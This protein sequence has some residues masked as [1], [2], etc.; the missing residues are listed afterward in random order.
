MA[1][2]AAA[3]WRISGTAEWRI[4]GPASVRTFSLP[5]DTDAAP[6]KLF[7][8]GDA[9]FSY[10][11]MCEAPCDDA[12]RCTLV[13]DFVAGVAAA[14]RRNGASLD[15]F[16]ELLYVEAQRRRQ[17]RASNRTLA[18]FHVALQRDPGPPSAK[19]KGASPLIPFRSRAPAA[20]Q[21]KIYGILKLMYDR[22]GADMYDDELK[23]RR[24][25]RS[26]SMVADADHAVAKVSKASDASD[27]SEASKTAKASKVSKVSN[28]SEPSVP[29]EGA[30]SL[31]RMHYADARSETVVRRLGLSHPL[32]DADAFRA[33][34]RTKTASGPS[35]SSAA[36]GQVLH[37]LL[38]ER[39]CASALASALGPAAAA[40]AMGTKGA[41][42]GGPAAAGT[43]GTRRT[44]PHR[45]AKQFLALRE[46]AL[47]E[48]LRRY[49]RDEIAKAVRALR[50]DADADAATG[51]LDVRK[52][53]EVMA[54][55]VRPVIMD[56][57]LLCRFARLC[58]QRRAAPGTPGGAGAAAIIYVG[59]L[60]A[61]NCARFFTLY[62]GVRPDA[63]RA[64]RYMPINK[65]FDRCVRVSLPAPRGR[66]S[67]K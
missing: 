37:A 48:A 5:T 3:E 20:Q 50:H 17:R 38:F 49:G 27:A 58:L 29:S 22:F 21:P 26:R 16:A 30:G 42:R 4:S 19:G 43:A 65:E 2:D 46:G 40:A 31:V 61:L 51:R 54:T 18:D 8:F 24:R 10:A 67:P 53:E 52:L 64:A 36:V 28:A 15:V 12:H 6:L 66:P 11:N 47:K 23:Q 32:T 44:Q 63:Q 13:T 33:M 41:S 9:H 62:M 59:E 60:H 7:L 25:G 39:D 57:Y 35:S 55:Y 56:F 45:V 34:F 14:A 1:A